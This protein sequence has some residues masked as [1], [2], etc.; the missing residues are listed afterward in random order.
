MSKLDNVIA[1]DGPAASGKSTVAGLIAE[2]TGGTYISTG[3][4]YRAVAVAAMDRRLVEPLQPEKIVHML[5][6]TTLEYRRTSPSSVELFLNGSPAG[7]SI[8]TPDAAKYSSA[9]S[10]I[11][12]VRRWLFD[13]QR[14]LASLGLVIMEG[15][16]IGTVIFPDAK[17]KFFL[18]ATPEA[19]AMRRLQQKG[20]TPDGA[21]VA[22]VAAEIA[23]RDEADSTRKVAPLRKADDAVLVDSTSMTIAEVVDFMMK[24]IQISSP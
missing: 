13:K 11:P 20:E 24:H 1:I 6:E 17:Y 19:R 2:K 12:E 3:N 10:A 8:R 18:T 22:S 21:T 5:E 4:M 15:R 7:D 16:D 23:K 9:I 14:E